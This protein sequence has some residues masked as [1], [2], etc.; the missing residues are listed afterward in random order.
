[1]SIRWRWI[2][3]LTVLLGAVGGYFLARLLWFK[4][5]TIEQFYD[6][7]NIDMNQQ[8]PAWMTQLGIFEQ[9]GLREHNSRLNDL[10]PNAQL[11]YAELLRNT[12]EL[13]N[14]YDTSGL[15]AAERTSY[16]VLEHYLTTELAGLAWQRHDYPINPF[17]GVQ[18]SLPGYLLQLEITDS[19][20]AEHYVASLGKISEQFTWL[21]QDLQER[22][23]QGLIAPDFVLQESITQIENFL[24]GGPASNLLLKSF[25]QKLEAAG[26]NFE[27]RL[28][29]YDQT[30]ALLQTEIYPAYQDLLQTLRDLLPQAYPNA[31]V[32]QLPGGAEYYDYLITKYTT[33][34]LTADELHQIGLLEVA[35]LQQDLRDQ[36]ATLNINAD[37]WVQVMAGLNQDPTQ[38]YEDS[39]LGRAQVLADFEAMLN[40]ISTYLGPALRLRPTAD[41]RVEAIPNY[42]SNAPGGYYQPPAAGEN[43]FGTF[44]VNLARMD[45]VP[46][47]SMK[48]LAVHEGI[49]GHHTQLALQAE[50]DSIPSFHRLLSIPVFSEGWALYAERLMFELG[51]YADDDLGNLGRIQ[52]ELFRAARLVVDTGIHTK[53]W[54]RAE[55]VDYMYNATGLPRHEVRAEVMRYIVQPGQALAYTV[56]MQEL[57]SLRDKAR[58]ELGPQFDLRD[59]HDAI[60]RHGSLPIPVLREVVNHY[61]AEQLEIRKAQ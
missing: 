35:R 48:T 47:Y 25:E 11:A 15:S 54:T 8:P 60:L 31:G 13:F 40:E 24:A 27:A 19:G 2:I 10:S 57:L 9:F 29:F 46:S 23:A 12:Y 17:N 41:L 43:S 37:D 20:S 6:R 22:A 44:Y 45:N 7:V 39:A 49:P 4:P 61:I 30:R 42:A 1:M 28:S 53:R 33:H 56:G 3:I 26:M 14:S 32:W 51:L 36:L 50:L 55:A 52:S 59:F 34:S 18:S 5:V 16:A 21:Q 38:L 58:R